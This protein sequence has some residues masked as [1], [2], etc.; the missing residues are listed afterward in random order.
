MPR[1]SDPSSRST[2]GLGDRW[3]SDA[4]I[5]H[6]L[7]PVALGGDLEPETLLAAYRAGLFPMPVEGGRLMAWWSPDPRAVL[8]PERFAPS[9]SLRRSIRRY[10]TTIDSCFRD[11]VEGCADP[12]RPHGWI[13]AEIADAYTRLHELGWA[14][15]IE[16]WYEGELVG[17]MYGVSIGAFFAGESKF[18]RARDASKV[19]VARMVELLEPYE[20]AVFDVQWITP[21]LASLGAVEIRQAEYLRRVR[22]AVESPGPW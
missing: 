7:G 17:G 16:V 2:A 20:E 6:G 1:S 11:V 5:L 15:S 21:H 12:A 14:H 18:H 13:T 9:R 4:P 10:E 22:T 19:A 3:V 8:P